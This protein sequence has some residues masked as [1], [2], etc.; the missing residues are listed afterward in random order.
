MNCP[1]C[2]RKIKRDWG[3]CSNCGYRLGLKRV[4]NPFK[5]MFDRVFKE[6]EEID[7]LFS[8][9][10]EV[11][12]ATPL[13][14]RGR[15]FSI[16]INQGG[17]EPRINVRTFGGVNKKR[18]E[19]ELEKKYGARPKRI[20]EAGPIIQ[21]KKRVID[22]VMEEPKTHI[23]RLSDKLVV[24][25]D[26]PNVKSENDVEVEELSE[27]I[28]VKAFGEDRAYFKIIKKP[29][30]FRLMGKQMKGDKLILEFS[31]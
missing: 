7:D 23:K 18:I 21:R 29:R 25:M 26:L 1:R 22:K 31:L 2:G 19:K 30:K 8:K 11:F 20:I 14:E 16:T 5:N 28:E 24:E 3:F 27:S 4:F 12:D 15:G 17:R 10:I 6:F 13:F 9:D